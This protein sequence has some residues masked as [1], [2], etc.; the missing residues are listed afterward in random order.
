MCIAAYAAASA[1][2]VHNPGP[3]ATR[4]RMRAIQL[5]NQNLPNVDDVMIY[6]VGLLWNLEVGNHLPLRL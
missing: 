6:A 4:L 3:D 2:P 5:V 1:D